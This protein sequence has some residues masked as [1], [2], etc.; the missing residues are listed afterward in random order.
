[1][2]KEEIIEYLKGF[3]DDDEPAFI[4]KSDLANLPVADIPEGVR[5]GVGA[6]RDGVTHVDWDGFLLRDGDEVVATIE[7]LWT[8][9]Y[10]YLPLNLEHYAS[11]VRRAVERRSSTHGDVQLEH[12]D[13]DGAYVSLHYSIH[14]LPKRSA[15]DAFDAATALQ[16]LMEEEADSLATTAGKMVEAATRRI[17][18]WG[19]EPLDAL[20]DAVTTASSTDEKGKSLEELVARLFEQVDGLSSIGRLRTQTEEIDITVLNNSEDPRLK[21]ETAMLLVE[22]KNWSSKC[23]KDE[24]VL[25]RQ[26]LENRS[27]RCG[28]GFLVSWNGF[29]S[30]VTKE[31]LR[32]SKEAV[33]VVPIDGKQLRRAVHD[34]NFPEVLF[35]AWQAAVM[36]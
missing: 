30:T 20:I 35:E 11:L 6:L 15:R 10:W 32:G 1:M 18:G 21:R 2:T 26:K 3:V 8:R 17:E 36:I 13:D 19:E 31:M 7:F 5:I 4:K 33:L 29:A 27:A 14:G 23:G 34:S 24:L 9:K 12:A 22:C 16:R 28:L 25:F